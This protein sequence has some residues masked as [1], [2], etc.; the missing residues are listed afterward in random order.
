MIGTKPLSMFRKSYL[1]Y[2][3]F[4][5]IVLISISSCEKDEIVDV[6]HGELDPK[7]S[8]RPVS[9]NELLS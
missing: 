7:I 6:Q 4:T 8:G 1:Y 9:I 3:F 2:L 5:V